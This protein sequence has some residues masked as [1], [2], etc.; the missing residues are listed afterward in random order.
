MSGSITVSQTAGAVLVAPA[1]RGL[2]GASAYDLAG[3]DGVWGSLAAWQASCA[4]GGVVE[5]NYAI[6]VTRLGQNV[7]PISPPPTMLSSLVL[8]INGIEYQAPLALSATETAIT[9]SGPFALDPT[10]D[11]HVSYF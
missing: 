7:L 11:V 3:G 9:W 2:A 6:A 8:T 1:V 10:D 4:V 5:R